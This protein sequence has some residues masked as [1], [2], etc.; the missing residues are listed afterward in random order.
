ME[1]TA[2]SQTFLDHLAARRF[3]ELASSLAPDAV[4]RFLLPP[5]AQ[6]TIGA[7]PIA[8]RFEGWFGGASSF[9]VLSTG[10]QPVGG[11][12]LLHWRFRLSRDG[13]STEVI[14]QVAFA[15][16]GPAG[17][18]RLDLLCSGFLPDPE[19]A[20]EAVLACE[21]PARALSA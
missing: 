10:N 3:E 13:Q 7:D 8:R 21:V 6:E 16:A 9:S 2:S 19:I 12:S 17:I 20:A 14:E 18:Y 15:D 11:R 1:T 4:A 5:G